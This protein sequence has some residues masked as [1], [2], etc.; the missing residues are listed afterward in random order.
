M[1]A[2]GATLVEQDGLTAYVFP[3]T[4]LGLYMDPVVDVHVRPHTAAEALA[5]Y[6]KA[7]AMLDGAMFRLTDRRGYETSQKA[8]LDYGARDDAHE[9]SYH[10]LYPGR[11]ITIA[12]H[13]GRAVVADGWSAPE[14]AHVAAQ[15]YPTLVHG[16]AVVARRDRNT[17]RVQRAGLAVLRDGRLALFVC[18]AGLRVVAE[19]LRGVLDAT[20]AGYTDGGGSTRLALRDGR[21]F[22]STENRR[23]ACWLL[24]TTESP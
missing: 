1:V 4:R 2:P 7:D 19:R 15:F 10:G 12:V 11:G 9:L 23:V 24:A 14:L 20:D 17:Q 3:A 8:M 21:W 6:P 5:A 18:K 16:G 13:D 22:G